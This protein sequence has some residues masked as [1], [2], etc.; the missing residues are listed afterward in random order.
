MTVGQL[1]RRTGLTA[2]SIRRFEGF[3]LI[4]SVGRSAAN[5]RL[6][7]ESAVWCV[8][9]I[10]SLRALGLTVREI[11]QLAA[12][13]LDRQDESVGPLLAEQL[14]NVRRRLDARAA[15]M[16]RVRDRLDTFEHSHA[17]ELA[18]SRPLAPW[19]RDPRRMPSRT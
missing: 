13:Y 19:A 12:L 8:E 15:E 1:A 17:A 4:Y 7:D 18:G 14:V 16:V 9:V 2:R 5:Y 3:G 6:F 11:R 10:R